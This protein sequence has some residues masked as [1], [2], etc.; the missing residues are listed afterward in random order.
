MSEL[1][2][3]RAKPEL[4]RPSL[5]VGWRGDAAEL[6]VRVAGYLNQNL[7]GQSFAEIEPL[8][9][10]PMGG[11]SIEDDL[12]QF[13]DSKFYWCPG[14]DL[15]LFSSNPPAH[16]WH[17]FLNLVIDIAQQGGPL[18]EIYTVGG[19]VSLSAHTAPRELLATFSSPELKREMDNFNLRGNLD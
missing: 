18:K 8:A 2:K 7:A 3:L 14:K 13:P 4:D 16:E 17:L 11:V 1:F 15:L 10:F 12:V 19:M 9:F 5:V 6:G